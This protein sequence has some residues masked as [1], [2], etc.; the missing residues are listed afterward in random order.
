MSATRPALIALGGLSVLMSFKAL[1]KVWRG[2]RARRLLAFE[3]EA[4]S[5]SKG[6]VLELRRSLFSK[7][8]SVS[9]SN[10]DP[11]MIMRGDGQYLIDDM[12]HRWLDTRNNVGHVV[13]PLEEH[14]LFQAVAHI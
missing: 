6:E 13:R 2:W 3:E 11:L 14:L 5:L 7:S 10:T 9:Y 1:M 12:G 8:Q 4:A